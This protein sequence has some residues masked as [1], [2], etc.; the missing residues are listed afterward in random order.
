MQKEKNKKWTYVTRNKG[1]I[2]GQI[3]YDKKEIAINK[4]Q[5]KR[6]QKVKKGHQ[7][8]FGMSKKETSVINTIVHELR[9]KTHPKEHEKT[10]RKNAKLTVKRLGKKR[11]Q[12]LYSKFKGR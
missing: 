9:H 10:V 5:S 12:K 1:P 11:K 8:K 2:F 6:A 7:E 4:S 3:N